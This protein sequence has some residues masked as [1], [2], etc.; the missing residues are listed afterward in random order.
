VKA[1]KHVEEPGIDGS[2]ILN[3]ER[4][5]MCGAVEWI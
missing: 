5:K 1:R 4:I 2:L 3:F